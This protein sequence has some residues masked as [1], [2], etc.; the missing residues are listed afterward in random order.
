MQTAKKYQKYKSPDDLPMLLKVKDLAEF[1]GINVNKAYQ[2]VK[3]NDFPSIQI[4]G[5][6]HIPRQGLLNWIKAKSLESFE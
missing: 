3:I 1:L 5:T 4:G 2:L 6:Y